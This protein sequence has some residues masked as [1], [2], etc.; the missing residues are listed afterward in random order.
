MTDPIPAPAPMGL[1]VGSIAS[2]ILTDAKGILL[3]QGTDFLATHPAALA[4]LEK[5]SFDMA[6]AMIARILESDPVKKQD[7]LDEINDDKDALKEE[8]YSIIVDAEASTK[9]I[10]WTILDD[11]GRIALGLGPIL[12]KA[13]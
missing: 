4:L 8:G 11:I 2:S 9:S 5:A 3:S 1:D 13:I 12:L 6:K 10:F 7:L